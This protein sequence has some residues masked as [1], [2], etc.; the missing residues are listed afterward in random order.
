[1][2]VFRIDRQLGPVTRPFATRNPQ[3]SPN[4]QQLAKFAMGAVWA[5]MA[6]GFSR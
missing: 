2:K 5:G 6:H 3:Q 1:L 4:S